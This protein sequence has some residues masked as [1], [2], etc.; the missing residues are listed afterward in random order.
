[1]LPEETPHYSKGNFDLE[2]KFDFGWKE[3][4]GN[5]YRGDYDLSQ[6]M[7][8]SG[9][10]LTVVTED[11]RKI[12]PHVVQPSF[13][14]ER[15]L[16]CILLHC[17]R[18]G[19]ERGWSWFQFP[20]RIAPYTAGIFP[21]VNKNNLPEKA[22]KIYNSLKQYYDV[23]YDDKTSIGK[24]YARADEIGV[25]VCITIDYQTFKDDTVTL[26][27]RDT[28]KQIR[29]KIDELPNFLRKIIEGENLFK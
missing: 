13:G 11:G 15:P 29:V 4:V 24:L 18:E 10:D 8:H 1:M 21:L 7:K 27:D 5:A 26:R 6:H 22:K 2:L 14:V 9:K 20:A 16:L 28:R 12:I 17:F 19:K 25:P 3:S 23:F